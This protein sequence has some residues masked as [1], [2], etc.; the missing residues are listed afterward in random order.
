MSFGLRI[1][2]TLLPLWISFAT[3]CQS[4]R[5]SRKESSNMIRNDRA[6]FY[7]NGSVRDPNGPVGFINIEL[8]SD[9]GRIKGTTTDPLTGDFSFSLTRTELPKLDSLRIAVLGYD[10]LLDVFNNDRIKDSLTI[11]NYTLIPLPVKFRMIIGSN[12]HN[13]K[14]T[15]DTTWLDREGR[16]VTKAQSDSI[17]RNEP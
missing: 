5:L 13:S 16:G 15:R 6:I 17:W 8:L 3:S 2:S 7:F 11:L 9:S 10:T 1:I 14:I 4:N 12:A